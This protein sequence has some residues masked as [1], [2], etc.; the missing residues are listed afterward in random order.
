MSEEL[1]PCPFCNDALSVD[2]VC[3]GT[4]LMA[5]S[6]EAWNTRPIEDALSAQVAELTA[7][8]ERMTA[9]LKRL[10]WN[11][12]PWI[13]DYCYVCHKLKSFGHTDECEL[14]KELRP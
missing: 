1:K 7:K 5:M 6:R 12:D 3:E 10:E 9:L 11:G 8:V 13:D 14:G 2:C 4:D